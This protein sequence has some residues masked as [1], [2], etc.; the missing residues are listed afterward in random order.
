MEIRHNAL[1]LSYWTLVMR[2]AVF[3][4]IALVVAPASFARA[5]VTDITSGRPDTSY[6]YYGLSPSY[7]RPITAEDIRRNEI[8]QQYREVVR[9]RI[10]DKKPSNDPW[11]GVR[12][13]ATA[14]TIGR[15][16]PE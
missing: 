12:P 1:L 2:R 10:P 8:E 14:I 5:Q 15:H 11:K 3:L 13:T 4:A 16:R 7:E 6:F 9:T